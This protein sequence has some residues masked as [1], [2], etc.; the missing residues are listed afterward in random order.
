MADRLKGK[1]ALVTG[2]GRGIGRAIALALAGEG[3]KLVINDLKPGIEGGDADSAARQ[4]ID[5]GGHVV[6][7]YGDVSNFEVARK[8]IQAAVDNFGRLDILVNNAGTIAHNPIW[9]MTEDD[10][11]K[12]VGSHLKGTFNC[13]RHASSLMKEQRWGRIINCTSATW[14]GT[15]GVAT[16]GAAKAGIVGLTRCV[17][18]DVAEYRV[19]CNAYQPYARTTM[20]PGGSS[21]VKKRYE[22]GIISK[23]EYEWQ[24]NPPLPEGAGPMIVYLATDEA[25]SINGRV[26]YISGNKVAIFS[27]PVRKKTIVKEEGIWTVE[28]LIEQVPK[29]LLAQG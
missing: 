14:L 12:V 4:I 9:D 11:D 2:S 21:V 15:A 17:A 7:F 3:A 25:A 26:F 29:V 1:V 8:L 27:E 28:E 10:Y 6:P 20:N 23:E 18:L 22:M 5:M 19:T 16:Y 13:T 24:I